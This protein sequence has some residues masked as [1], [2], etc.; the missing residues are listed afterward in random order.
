MPN[1]DLS[2]RQLKMAVGEWLDRRTGEDIPA[3]LQRHS[4]RR[5][6]N[7]LLSFLYSPVPLVKWRAVTAIG[8]LVAG[9]ADQDL[10]SAR[11]IM[12]RLMWSLNDESGGIGWG[13]P[14]S[15]GEIMARHPRLAREFHAILISYLA[16]DKNYLEHEGLQPGLLWGIGRLARVRKSLVTAA[17]KLLP[18]YLTSP[19]TDIRGHAAWAAAALD[20][21][22]LRPV[23]KQLG[24]D[25]K[26][27]TLYRHQQL[28]QI[29]VGAA[30][31]SKA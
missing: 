9:L 22:V 23:L 1:A 15:M 4:V 26:I 19:D 14:E 20:S 2:N 30:A 6:I 5:L 3:D 24:D 16:P 31:R 17:E 12:R 18:P 11:I 25:H 10:E 8:C 13:A 27:F 29:S 21:E 7:P 28:E